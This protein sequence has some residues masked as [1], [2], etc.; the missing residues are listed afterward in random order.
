MNYVQLYINRIHLKYKL[1]IKILNNL[2]LE[3][4][5]NFNNLQR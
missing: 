1:L 3:N 2:K 4:N 5:M